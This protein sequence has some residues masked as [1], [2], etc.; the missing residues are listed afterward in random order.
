MKQASVSH[1]LV[2]GAV[3]LALVAVA[4][5]GGE[6]AQAGGRKN[7]GC[8]S[9][10]CSC[11]CH[12]SCGGCSCGGCS[13]GG[14]Y[15]NGCSCGGCSCGGYCSGGCSCGG[16]YSCSGGC[17]CAMAYNSRSNR[18]APVYAQRSTQRAAGP[19]R[20][21]HRTYAGVVPPGF[22][23]PVTRPAFTP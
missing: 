5:I 17:D 14:C 19:D 6:Q 18:T 20:G 23:P 1:V 9:C 11:S 4:L 3:I 12:C 21:Q 16:C 13:C 8:C 10:D 15:C 22:V 2:V 7:C